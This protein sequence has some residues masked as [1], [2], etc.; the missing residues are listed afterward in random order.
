MSDFIEVTSFQTKDLV[1]L[2]PVDLLTDFQFDNQTLIEL[3]SNLVTFLIFF[4]TS[5][6]LSFKPINR[7][8]LVAEGHFLVIC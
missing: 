2:D 4:Y 7:T 6:C 3:G 1:S 5:Q 8:T